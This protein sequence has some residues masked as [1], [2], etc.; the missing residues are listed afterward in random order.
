MVDVLKYNKETKK[1]QHVKLT[2][3]QSGFDDRSSMSCPQCY[4]EAGDYGVVYNFTWQ[5][6]PAGWNM[7]GYCGTCSFFE[8]Q[9]VPY[10]EEE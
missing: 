5:E 2:K 4:S 8:E 3:G 1:Y 6:N 10:N 7:R 9:F